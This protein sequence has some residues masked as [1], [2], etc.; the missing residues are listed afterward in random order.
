MV[1]ACTGVPL[2][3]AETPRSR[4]R[5]RTA[6]IFCMVVLLWPAAGGRSYLCRYVGGVTGGLRW[7]YVGDLTQACNRVTL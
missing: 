7:G 2:V 1:P 6:S 4:V 3:R 5:T